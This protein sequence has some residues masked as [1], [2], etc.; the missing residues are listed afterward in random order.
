MSEKTIH[1]SCLETSANSVE[2][3]NKLRTECHSGTFQKWVFRRD[4]HMHG[5]G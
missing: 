5:I 2:N 4:L 1:L 3:E